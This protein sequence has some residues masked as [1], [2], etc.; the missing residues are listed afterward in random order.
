M[1]RVRI[2]ELKN[3]IGKT[4]RLFGRVDTRRDHGKLIFFDLRD[5]TGKLQI[6]VLPKPENVHS[7]AD[8][9]R[10]EWVVMFEGVVKER[11]GKMI[12][13]D[14]L[15]GDLEMELSSLE[16]VSES[17]TAPFDIDSEGFDIKEELRMKYRYIDLRRGRLQKNIRRRSAVN[18]FLRNFL[19]KKEFVE[20]ETP[21]L[22]RS[23]P[24]GAR[25]Y[26]VPSRIYKG[27][28]YAL[29][30]SP[31]QYKQL[32][33]MGGFERYFQFA[34]CLRDEDTRGDRQPE[35]T[36]LDIEW[37]FAEREDIMSLIEELFTAMITELYPEKHITKTPWPILEYN[38]VVKKYGSDRPD[39]R[40]DPKDENELGFAWVIDFP[41]FE[42]EKSEE[43]YF[44]PEHHMFTAPKK[45]DLELLQTA[46]QKVRSQQ[47]DLSLN[48]FEVA[49]GSIRIHDAKTQK[50]V[51]DLI[52]FSEK[53]QNEFAHMLSAFRYGVPPHGGIAPGLD[54][55]L[56]VLENEKSIREVIA[57]PKTGEGRDPMMNIPSEIGD[58]QLKELGL[59]IKKPKE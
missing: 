41:L 4:V 22:T 35:F 3:H 36:Q 18:N 23:T 48:G 2:K 54:R 26:V 45:E 9:L 31:Q 16:V 14:E 59:R 40:K 44:L 24:E 1:K 25:D 51:F 38:E 46:P 57:F 17:E 55:I 30:Q 50:T 7:S 39:I 12:N 10:P 29:P 56:S 53:E 28:F 19:V 42:K 11:P 47:M 27:S 49:G 37:A 33:M 32:L 6:V 20:I 58:F 21:I 5:E 8:K 15:M 13:P 43:G 52:G 34:R